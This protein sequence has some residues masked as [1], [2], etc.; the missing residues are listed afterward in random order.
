MW[1]H[2]RGCVPSQRPC[3]GGAVFFRRSTVLLCTATGGWRCLIF[4]IFFFFS[5]NDNQANCTKYSKRVEQDESTLIWFCYKTIKWYLFQFASTMAQN[6][7]P[8]FVNPSTRSVR[9][10]SHPLTAGVPRDWKHMRPSCPRTRAKCQRIFCS[11]SYSMP[12][13]WYLF[14]KFPRV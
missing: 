4:S 6:Y 9:S 13:K 2:I 1:F 10:R 5:K 14:W 7:S 12:E 11:G 8:F 3:P